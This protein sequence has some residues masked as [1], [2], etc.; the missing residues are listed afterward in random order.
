MNATTR[1]G[2]RLLTDESGAT[3]IEYGLLAALIALAIIG[4]VASLG[5]GVMTN[6]F[7]TTTST[8]SSAI[9]SAS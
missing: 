5:N 9:E 6:L 8:L 3:A 1:I 4:A 2:R 7:Q